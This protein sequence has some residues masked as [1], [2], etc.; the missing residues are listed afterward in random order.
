MNKLV[1][2]FASFLLFTACSNQP[3]AVKKYYRLT[4]LENSHRVINPEKRAS[5]VIT[6][7]KAFSILAG[8][9]MVATQ[10][11]GA[12]VQL[13]YHLWLES[14]TLLLHQT[15]KNWAETHWQLAQTSAAFNEQ[16][17]RLDS[18]ILAFEK[19]GNR[20]K[21]SI[22]FVLT[23]VDGR[24]LL[25][26]TLSQNLPVQGDGYAQFVQAINRALNQIL[27]D[28]SAAISNLP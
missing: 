15:L 4:S 23:A 12:L 21:V 19:D 25:D 18:Q 9:P 24:V 10:N 27:T 14:P 6:R 3:A 26:Q 22:H 8:R 28:L 20:A 2:L 7:P 17:E 1:I 16:H 13:N 11:D 5:V